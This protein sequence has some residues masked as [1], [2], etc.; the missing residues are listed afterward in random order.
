MIGRAPPAIQSGVPRLPAERREPRPGFG[1]GSISGDDA[2]GC[3]RDVRPVASCFSGAGAAACRRPSASGRNVPARIT[4][5]PLSGRVMVSSASLSPPPSSSVSSS[6]HSPPAIRPT[7]RNE[8]NSSERRVMVKVSPASPRNDPRLAERAV[9]LARVALRQPAVQ[10]LS[11]RDGHGGSAGLAVGDPLHHAACR[12]RS[13]PGSIALTWMWNAPSF[14]KLHRDPA[15]GAAAAVV[16]A[17]HA[18][19]TRRR[20]TRP[21][22]GRRR[23]PPSA[24]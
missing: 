16:V 19:C 18:P 4:Y 7:C 8:S 5:S 12:R 6:S 17:V 23:S 2:T 1:R 24:A 22:S 9:G 14:G 10:R 13:R 20:R 3:V 11:W 21:A 15:V